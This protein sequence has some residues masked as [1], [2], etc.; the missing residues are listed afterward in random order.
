MGDNKNLDEVIRRLKN[1]TLSYDEYWKMMGVPD[2]LAPNLAWTHF[3]QVAPEKLSAQ[4][5]LNFE[6]ALKLQ[7]FKLFPKES[8]IRENLAT[9][10]DE[11]AKNYCD[12]PENQGKET[13]KCYNSA[14]V[15]ADR[16]REARDHYNNITIPAW[17]EEN[18]RTKAEHNAKL[19]AKA[20]RLKQLQYNNERKIQ[21]S[22]CVWEGLD[23]RV[24]NAKD[25]DVRDLGRA[26]C[27]WPNK[28]YDVYFSDS[29]KVRTERQFED[30]NKIEDWK[31]TSQPTFTPPNMVNQCCNNTVNVGEGG[32]SAQNIVQACNQTAIMGIE[33]EQEAEKKAAED[34][35]KKKQEQEAAAIRKQEEDAIRKEEEEAAIKKEEEE[36]LAAAEKKAKMIKIVIVI[37][38]FLV[39]G[40]VAALM[41][42][43]SE[44]G[45]TSSPSESVQSETPLSN[46]S[47]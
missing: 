32:S 16:D 27:K 33:K 8:Y 13:C 7:G 26:D 4:Y 31:E 20:E 43:K 22:G 47:A 1:R 12:K 37:V 17:K 5:I 44:S 39:L 6:K 46:T 36:I 9:S 2:D 15:L 21:T 35:A 19:A 18:R 40:G 28:R 30:N 14:K 11:A 42:F 45:E 25:Y 34:A 10:A 38:V 23:Y 29:Y 24:A 41:F 3:M